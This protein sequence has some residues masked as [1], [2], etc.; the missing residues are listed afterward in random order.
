MSGI[1]SVG[2]AGIAFIVLARTISFAWYMWGL[3]KQYVYDTA[4]KVMLWWDA[5]ATRL[6]GLLL[7]GATLWLALV[8]KDDWLWAMALWLVL[9]VVLYEVSVWITRIFLGQLSEAIE[10]SAAKKPAR[11]LA[12]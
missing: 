3:R 1:L 2:W 4:E 10:E 8:H 6:F 5:L 7:A 9:P 12:L 11:T